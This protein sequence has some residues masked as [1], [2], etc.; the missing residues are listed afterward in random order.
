MIAL[1]II[2]FVL[3]AAAAAYTIYR[4]QRA[5]ALQQAALEAGFMRPR[6]L[7][8][9]PDAA[10]AG[11][12]QLVAAQTG[13]A[14]TVRQATLLERAAVGD[15]TALTGAHRAHEQNL[16]ALV[17]NELTER[18]TT[19]E[20]ELSALTSFINGHPELRGN[21]KLVEAHRKIWRRAPHRAATGD[22]LHL[23]ALSDD[24][25]TFASVLEETVN[26]WRQGRLG[27]IKPAALCALIEGE[28]WVLGSDAR[29]TGAG[30]I[31]KER[32]AALRRELA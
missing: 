15:V 24:A 28:Y 31:L 21:T 4:R 2:A 9:E 16:Y 23:A 30:F 17:L 22:M 19:S 5:T 14:A 18:A 12:R 20:R 8:A 6:S 3:L 13:E 1:L 11:A 25:D 7:F 32:L 26:F 10:A 29:R 27:E